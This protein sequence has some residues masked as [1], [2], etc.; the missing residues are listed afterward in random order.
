MIILVKRAFQKNLLRCKK[1]VLF[2]RI[3][4]SFLRRIRTKKK[5][6]FIF[7]QG[8]KKPFSNR[9]QTILDLRKRRYLLILG[10]KER[11]LSKAAGNAVMAEQLFHLFISCLIC[12]EL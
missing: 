12:T 10:I 7:Y 2:Q 1:N 9:F 6:S 5:V 3:F 8:E 4:V 11:H